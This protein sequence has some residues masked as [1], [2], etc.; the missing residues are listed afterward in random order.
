MGPDLKRHLKHYKLHNP[1]PGADQ[2][3]SRFP[4]LFN[5][6]VVYRVLL[7]LSSVQMAYVVYWFGM[8]TL[9]RA[10][11]W[12]TQLVWF[13]LAEFL[14]TEALINRISFVAFTLSYSVAFILILMR[15]SWAMAALVVAVII[16]RIDWITVSS[17][18][19]FNNGVVGWFEIGLQATLILLCWQLIDLRKFR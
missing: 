5:S 11:M 1:T 7:V 12:P 6:D 3:G 19:A 4:P 17:N 15:R 16:A 13:D 9:G 2:G 10:G 8:E 14:R 18:V